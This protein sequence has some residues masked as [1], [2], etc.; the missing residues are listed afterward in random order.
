MIVR[1]AVI[2]SAITPRHPHVG[3]VAG[4]VAIGPKGETDD[5]LDYIG[6]GT[7]VASVIREKAPDARIYAVKIFDRAL[8]A[9]SGAIVRALDWCIERQIHIVNLSLGTENSRRRAQF[10]AVIARAQGAGVLAV[11][12]RAFLPGS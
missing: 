7:A 8:S 6:H 4:G 10:E 11:S 3:E 1:V 12:A 2:D 9:S 5:Y